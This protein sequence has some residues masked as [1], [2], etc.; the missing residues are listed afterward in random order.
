MLQLSPGAYLLGGSW[1]KHAAL[2]NRSVP[3]AVFADRLLELVGLS[4]S[5]TDF[6]RVDYILSA[7]VQEGSN[8]QFLTW[9]PAVAT[10]YHSLVYGTP[11]KV[12]FDAPVESALVDMTGWVSAPPS[13]IID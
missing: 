6:E 1:K 8:L 3:A 13:G 11:R 9:E 10:V 4:L 5:R 12:R 2:L 7:Q